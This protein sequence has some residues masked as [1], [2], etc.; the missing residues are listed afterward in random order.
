MSHDLIDTAVRHDGKVCIEAHVIPF[1]RKRAPAG[2]IKRMVTRGIG[3]SFPG[4]FYRP[5]VGSWKREWPLHPATSSGRQRPAL[6]FVRD[7]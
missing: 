7:F 1:R 5:D 3:S 6:L 2:F 4:L